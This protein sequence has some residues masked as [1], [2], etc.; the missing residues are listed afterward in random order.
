MG[1]IKKLS[2]KIRCINF[3]EIVL[4]Y[5]TL[6]I[7][8]CVSDL[9]ISIYAIYYTHYWYY[10]KCLLVNLSEFQGGVS[11]YSPP[12]SLIIASLSMPGSGLIKI[13]YTVNKP[14]HCLDIL[15]VFYLPVSLRKENKLHKH[16]TETFIIF[17]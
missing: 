10:Q 12:F 9:Y 11:R 3:F 7:W 17:Y 16:Q 6:P 5:V 2:Y 4:L 8:D 1:E 13:L 15:I 14:N